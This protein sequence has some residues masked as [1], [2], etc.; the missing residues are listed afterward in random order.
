MKSLTY[1]RQ[2][3]IQRGGHLGERRAGGRASHCLACAL[4]GVYIMFRSLSTFICVCQPCRDH[5]IS[6]STSF[7]P[8]PLHARSTHAYH[9]SHVVLDITSHHHSFPSPLPP[10]PVTQ[11]PAPQL[12]RSSLCCSSTRCAI[13]VSR[14]PFP[15]V[16]MAIYYPP[17]AQPTSLRIPPATGLYYP[18]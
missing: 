3:F 7:R 8:Q 4:A 18:R 15:F 14:A 1:C 2:E 16:S 17:S 12:L 10:N 11:L 13:P 9:A 5:L 6:K